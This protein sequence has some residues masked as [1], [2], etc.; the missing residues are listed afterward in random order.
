MAGGFTPTLHLFSQLRGKLT[1]DDVRQAFRPAVPLEHV[2]L[3]G[4]CNGPLGLK[5]G[6]EG[7]AAAGEAA[8]RAVGRRPSSGPRVVVSGI[9]AWDAATS[10]ATMAVAPRVVKGRAY[11]DFQNDV[12][13]KDL[14]LAA[15][16][17]FRSVEHIKRYTTTGMATD[18]GKTSNVNALSVV[19]AALGQ[20]VG[21]LG[22][23]TFRAPFT[24]V[25]VS[26]PA[27]TNSA[28]G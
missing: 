27:C 9:A 16:E 23:T 24:P 25:R 22:H 5:G 26:N 10:A 19:S 18:Q 8:A 11:V 20:G 15:Q 14:Q 6:I 7:G 4:A 12:T 17:G 21:T 3:A 1:W 13:T 28:W 2:H